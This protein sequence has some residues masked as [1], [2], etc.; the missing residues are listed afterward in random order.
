MI[1]TDKK[2]LTSDLTREE[3]LNYWQYIG[4]HKNTSKNMLILEF[5]VFLLGKNEL[6][7]RKQGLN[8]LDRTVKSQRTSERKIVAIRTSS[9]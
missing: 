4:M 6:R 1:K 9:M 2:G 5:V 3:I 7:H 8:M